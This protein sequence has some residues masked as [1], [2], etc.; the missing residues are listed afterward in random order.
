MR[1]ILE[2]QRTY[3]LVGSTGTGK[4][5]LA[6]MIFYNVG[7]TTRLGTIPNGNTVLDYEPEEIKKGASGGVIG[8]YV[9]HKPTGTEISPEFQMYYMDVW[10]KIKAKWILPTFLLKE[11]QV[12]EAIVIIKI[13]R[14]GNIVKKMFEKHSG[15]PLFDQSVSEAIEKANP[16]PPLP[17]DYTQP[18][19]EIG[20][21]FRWSGTGKEVG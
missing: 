16:L 15:N 12:L 9:N 3:A 4:T 10:E 21:R 1:D 8:E 14:Q 7:V 19:H 2:K 5:S 6:E 11:S 18:Y 13:D 20:V 17:P